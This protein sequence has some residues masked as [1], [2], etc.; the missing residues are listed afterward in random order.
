MAPIGDDPTQLAFNVDTTDLERG[1]DTAQRELGEL[2]EEAK[3][4]IDTAGADQLT[5]ALGRVAKALVIVQSVGAILKSVG[6]GI[7]ALDANNVVKLDA[8]TKEWTNSIGD[9]GESLARLDPVGVG[10][11]LGKILGGAIV[12]LTDATQTLTVVNRE[13]GDSL[14]YLGAKGSSAADR[15]RTVLQVQREFVAAQEKAGE[16]LAIR[17]EAITRQAEVEAQAGEVTKATRDE[18]KR[19]LDTYERIGEKPP[20]SLAKVTAE[21]GI[22]SAAAERAAKA[23]KEEGE[24]VAKASEQHGAL[25]DKLKAVAEAR[26]EETASTE[27]ALVKLKE[28]LKLREGEAEE[29]QR[30]AGGAAKAAEDARARLAEIEAKPITTEGEE[31]ERLELRRKLNALESEAEA[32]AQRNADAAADLEAAQAA[33]AAQTDG[34]AKASGS[35]VAVGG[36]LYDQFGKVGGAAEE[37]GAQVEGV[38]EAASGAAVRMEQAF[39]KMVVD[40]QEVD[41][42][43][44]KITNTSDE[45]GEGFRTAA[46]DAR[47]YFEG[48]QGAV[49]EFGES[50]DVVAGKVGDAAEGVQRIGEGTDG[51]V[52]KVDQLAAAWGRVNAEVSTYEATLGRVEAAIKR[53][54]ALVDDGAVDAAPPVTEGAGA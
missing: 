9:L 39:G 29:A 32:Q 4:P 42:L 31:V 27:E 17:T 46:D 21:L 20:E 28:E 16:K 37:A 50:I 7:K 36:E 8:E 33:L 52:G 30:A 45:L 14:D 41:V 54:E 24:A 11:D 15:L 12:D 47:A 5:A 48:T 19:L 53:H 34:T 3:K 35:L 51:Q 6:E 22:M 18:L 13:A 43:M 1:F 40:G 23:T 44:T 2:R 49:A 38:G 10:R 26:R 25:V